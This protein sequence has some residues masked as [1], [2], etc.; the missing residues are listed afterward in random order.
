M[1]LFFYMDAVLIKFVSLF[2]FDLLESLQ[3][4]TL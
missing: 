3:Y 4:F 2:Y 1:L